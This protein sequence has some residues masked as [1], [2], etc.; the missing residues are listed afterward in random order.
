[1]GD[2]NQL[3]GGRLLQVKQ[4]RDGQKVTTSQLFMSVTIL[5]LAVQSCSTVIVKLKHEDHS[6]RQKHFRAE[7][8][9]T[10]AV[11]ALFCRF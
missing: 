2:D 5:R 6:F 3:A 8:I 9:S 4:R 10:I 1:M 7:I 11:I